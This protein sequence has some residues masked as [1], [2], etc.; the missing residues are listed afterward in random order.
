MRVMQVKLGK[1]GRLV[2]PADYRKVLGLRAGDQVVVQLDGDHLQVF[3]LRQAVHY[4]QGIVRQY[5]KSDRS[6]ADELVRERHQETV[7]E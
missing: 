5:V 2:I 3:T 4:A 1:A 7:D 6:L